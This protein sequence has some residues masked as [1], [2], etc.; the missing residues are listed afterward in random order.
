MSG[1]PRNHGEY[2]LRLDSDLG[3][4]GRL[5]EFIEAFCER[6][7]LAE[8]VRD[9][10]TIAL[11]ELM[12]NAVVH[13]HCDP[14]VGAIRIGLQFR[15]DRVQIA[16]SDT[17][18]PFNPLTVPPPNLG[19]DLGSR[20]I[21]GLGIYFVRRLIPEARYERRDGRNVLFMTKLIEPRTPTDWEP[22]GTN[23]NCNHGDRAR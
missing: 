22:G 13:G 10:L 1:N 5:R 7:E 11:E 8:Q 16:F 9:Q 18:M 2:S 20:P 4:L 15:G 14:R 12:V 6:N 3:A 21:G 23:A 19:E 17:G